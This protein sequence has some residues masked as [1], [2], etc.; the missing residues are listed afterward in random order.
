MFDCARTARRSP[1]ERSGEIAA[2]LAARCCAVA[3]MGPRPIGR[4]NLDYPR[5]PWVKYD[6]ASMGPRPIGRGNRRVRNLLP[7]WKLV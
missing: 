4:G 7:A 6:P 2:I 5:P 3:S 1:D